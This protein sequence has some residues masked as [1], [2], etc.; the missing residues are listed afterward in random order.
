MIGKYEDEDFIVELTTDKQREY[1]KELV[2]DMAN[3]EIFELIQH[4]ND[5]RSD[6]IRKC[7]KGAYQNKDML[8][9]IF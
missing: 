1:L 3:D 2:K 4:I 7:L 5:V 8:S 9:H 6:V